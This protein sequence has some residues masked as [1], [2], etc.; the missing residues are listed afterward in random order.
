[1]K[2][3]LVVGARP[4]SI[5]AH[6]A[7]WAQMLGSHNKIMTAGETAHEDVEFTADSLEQSIAWADE[8]FHDYEPMHDVVCTVG[9]NHEG[10]L[11]DPYTLGL[12]EEDFCINVLGPM[13]VLQAWLNYWRS[14]EHANVGQLNFVVISSNSA[15]VVR[16]TGLPYNASKAALSMAV[17]CAARHTAANFDLLSIYAY[18]PGWVDN[19][20]MSNDV[21]HR[22]PKGVPFT[23][24]PGG[25]TITPEDLASIIVHNLRLNTGMLNGTTLR[26]DGGES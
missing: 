1:M 14:H 25:R 11:S 19:T 22:I 20:P 3:L 17:K 23:R 6:V 12:M 8:L 13:A 26:I 24:T 16:S 5:G 21:A 9:V 10:T 2:N 15:G 18:E 4:D 7:A